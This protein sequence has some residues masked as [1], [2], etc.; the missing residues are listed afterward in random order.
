MIWRKS[1]QTR[2]V[3]N[4]SPSGLRFLTLGGQ[5]FDPGEAR[6]ITFGWSLESLAG[7]EVWRRLAQGD[8]GPLG[9]HRSLVVKGLKDEL[10]EE[11]G[12]CL[13][14]SERQSFLLLLDPDGCLVSELNPESEALCCAWCPEG[15]LLASG[16]A[17]E[18]A[19]EHMA[20]TL[21]TQNERLGER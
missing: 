19:W 2:L 17:T 20:E 15:R 3:S 9:L 13:P 6:L 12:F 21:N 7:Q 10:I 5:E 18:E 14:P 8:F 4:W 1:V 16:M 11:L